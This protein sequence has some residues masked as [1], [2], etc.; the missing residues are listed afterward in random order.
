[1]RS[2]L[3][4]LLAGLLLAV[5]ANAASIQNIG[6]M[7]GVTIVI[8][9]GKIVEGD[10]A[11][12]RSVTS[13]LTGSTLVALNSPGGSVGEGL[14]IGATIRQRGYN[15]AVAPGD[16]CA[17]VCGLIWLAGTQRLLSPS[18]SVGF[19]A[20]YRKDGSESGMGNALVGAYL[21]DLGYSIET[22]AY[23]TESR[24]DDM[25]WLTPTDAQKYG[26]TYRLVP[27]DPSH[28]TTFGRQER[29]QVAPPVQAPP[30]VAHSSARQQAIDFVIAYNAYWS[31]GGADVEGLA[32]YYA[33]QINFYG[34]VTPREQV[35]V[36]KR[37]FAARWPVRRYTVDR[38]TLN[39]DCTGNDCV[40]SGVVAWDCISQ[41][42][43]AHSS[44]TANFALHITNG[45]IVAENGSVRSKNNDQPPQASLTSAYVQGRQA[46][47]D[48]EQWVN[49]L[50][51]GD[52]KAGVLF[53]AAHRSERPQPDCGGGS[54]IWQAGCLASRT[55][56]ATSDERRLTETDYRAGWNSL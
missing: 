52:Y 17:S 16:T 4:G 48:Y 44:G 49:A 54:V 27:D 35:M 53:W 11:M 15:T 38:P 43:G 6:A 5:T 9:N 33:P 32:Q 42:R 8:I 23:I 29:P 1:M 51:E 13:S 50:P 26:I 31:Q 55:R 18:S 21:R 3:Y 24:P 30:Q 19:H 10:L 56:L 45:A 34:T 20:A 22:I 12:F 46:R 2:I 39:V 25:S 14:A 41:E 36:A 40:V 7:N 28:G 37:K 47:I